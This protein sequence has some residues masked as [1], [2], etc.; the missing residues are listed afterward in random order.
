M[1]TKTIAVAVVALF[2][3]S[4]FVLCVLPATDNVDGAPSGNWIDEANRSIA[5]YGDGSADEFTIEDEMDLAGLSFLVTRRGSPVS[6][7]DK[8]IIVNPNLNEIDLSAHY[9]E[10][11]GSTTYGVFAGTFEGNGVLINGITFRYDFD[12]QGLFGNNSGTINNVGIGKDSL[13]YGYGVVGSIAALNNG[14][15]N[16]CYNLGNVFGEGSGVG[17]IVGRNTSIITDCY[18]L[19][20]VKGYNNTGGIVGNNTGEVSNCYNMGG[21]VRS[22]GSNPNFGG[23]VGF[24]TGRVVENCYNGIV[25]SAPAMPI[26]GSSSGTIDTCFWLV[27][28]SPGSGGL[29]IEDMSTAASVAM[30][31]LGTGWEFTDSF[32]SF[33]DN[34]KVTLF[35]Q[36]TVFTDSD[37]ERVKTDSMVSVVASKVEKLPFPS[38]TLVQ[39]G[40]YNYEIGQKIGDLATDE[41]LPTGFTPEFDPD[42]SAYIWMDPDRVLTTLGDSTAGIKLVSV[43]YKTET[44]TVDI[45][46]GNK[47]FP[48]DFVFSQNGDYSYIIGDTLNDLPPDELLPAGWADPTSHYVWIDGDEELTIIGEN[49]IV[50]MQVISDDYEPSPLFDVR[51]SVAK[52]PFPAT[53]EFVQ[54]GVYTLKI[55]EKLSTLTPNEALPTGWTADVGQYVWVDGDVSF[56]TAGSFTVQLQIISDEFETGGP[57]TVAISVT[58]EPVPPGPVPPKPEPIDNSLYLV[59]A[60]VIAV[61]LIGAMFLLFVRDDE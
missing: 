38:F 22:F 31:A 45:Y 55:G 26:A 32:V 21:L 39:S 61:A 7:L 60:L 10:S 19:G 44:F 14:T 59:I 36:L 42:T 27:D 18:N 28:S 17:G 35:P 43:E 11:I 25:L 50:K 9:W 29:L 16:G 5:W 2:M 54:T 53:F 37:N 48:S 40:T 41:E 3:A 20:E 51:I 58:D 8:T 47:A 33:D 23:I 12:E 49:I 15:I 34:Y 13:T 56:T 4:A 1:K 6:F 46:V 52:K 24:N 30:A 57:F